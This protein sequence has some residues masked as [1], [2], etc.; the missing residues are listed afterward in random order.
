[1]GM[2]FCEGMDDSPAMVR[3]N[4]KHLQS[5]F[6][7]AADIFTG[8]DWELEAQAALFAT[9][10][11]INLSSTYSVPLYM[12][13]SCEAVKNGGLQFVPTYGRPPQFSE[14]LHEKLSVL[15]QIIYFENFLFLT[16]GGAEPTMTAA[17]E[18]EFRCQLPVRTSSSSITPF[19]QRRSIGSLPGFIQNLSVSH[20]HEGYLVR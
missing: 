9:A 3:L 5:C 15:S 7:C 11:A 12:R 18:K 1:M 20:A 4:A 2:Y 13:K 8:Y 6:E 10:A 16:S 14:A 17:I 19:P